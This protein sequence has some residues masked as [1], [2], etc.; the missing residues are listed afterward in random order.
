MCSIGV[1]GKYS[2]KSL[3]LTMA[4]LVVGMDSSCEGISAN[5]F[6]YLENDAYG[7]FVFIFAIGFTVISN[8][9]LLNVLIAMFK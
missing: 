3:N 5:V 8:V 9:L 1:F 6:N 7:T 4:L 2:D